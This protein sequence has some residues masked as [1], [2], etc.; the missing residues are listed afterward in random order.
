M[1]KA[2]K[3]GEGG[4]PAPCGAIQKHINFYL[5]MVESCE[6]LVQFLLISAAHAVTK[7]RPVHRIHTT[8]KYQTK[9]S[10]WKIYTKNG[11]RKTYNYGRPIE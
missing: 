11:N 7:I 2:E 6:P 5:C 3:G 8:E 1:D 10:T 4:A 9:F